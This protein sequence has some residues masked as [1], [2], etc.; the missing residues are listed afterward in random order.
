[1]NENAK[2][3][4]AMLSGKLRPEDCPEHY[5]AL[6]DSVSTISHSMIS[7]RECEYTDWP[8]VAAMAD[9]LKQRD[10]TIRLLTNRLQELEATV[11]AMVD[12]PAEPEGRGHLVQMAEHIDG[13]TKEGRAMKAM[14]GAT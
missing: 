5:V 13:R 11:A 10:D 8:M 12:E 7:R 14:A 3:K 1:M 4:F 2:R 9:A 6:Y